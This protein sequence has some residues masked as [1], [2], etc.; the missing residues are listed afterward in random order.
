VAR[1]LQ[2]FTDGEE[3]NNNADGLKI[4]QYERW[5]LS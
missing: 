3:P 5:K 4:K 2:T 1:L